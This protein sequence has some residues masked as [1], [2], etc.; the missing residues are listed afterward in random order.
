APP[1]SRSLTP[2]QSD[3]LS[4]NSDHLFLPKVGLVSIG[5]AFGE[6]TLINL[7]CVLVSL[8]GVIALFSRNLRRFLAPALVDCFQAPFCT[9]TRRANGLSADCYENRICV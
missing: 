7:S 2:L 8:F 5:I 1:P 3:S 9:P 6:H 4:C